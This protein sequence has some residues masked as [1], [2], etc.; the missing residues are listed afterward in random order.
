[1]IR[2][3]SP[4]SPPKNYKLNFLNEFE[5]ST[6]EKNYL[7]NLIQKTARTFSTAAEN[8]EE[9]SHELCKHYKKSVGV[10]VIIANEQYEGERRQAYNKIPTMKLTMNE[11][12]YRIWISEP[13]SELESSPF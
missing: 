7:T 9:L 8:Q 1:M 4:R 11:F 12:F 5:M 3:K 13:A 6:V 10:S 2:S